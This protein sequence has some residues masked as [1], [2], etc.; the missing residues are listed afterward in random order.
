MVTHML[1]LPDPP[2]ARERR[3][4]LPA[5][6]E[7]LDPF[8]ASP[9]VSA[10]GNMFPDYVDRLPHPRNAFERAIELDSLPLDEFQQMDLFRGSCHSG[11]EKAMG[12]YVD[13][14]RPVTGLLR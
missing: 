4:P 5:E 8:H 10:D 7:V 11:F 12:A 13:T 1:R 14:L 3:S 9:S 6:A 2:P